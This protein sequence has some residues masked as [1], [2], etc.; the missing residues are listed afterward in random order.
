MSTPVSVNFK[1]GEEYSLCVFEDEY[2]R[3]MSYLKHNERYTALPGGGEKSCNYV[4]IAA[5]HL[6]RIEGGSPGPSTK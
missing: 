1:A 5:L 2:C 6:L 4:N 3:N